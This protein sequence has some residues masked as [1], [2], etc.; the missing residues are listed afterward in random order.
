MKYLLTQ[1][2]DG[3]KHGRVV[4]DENGVFVKG[5]D[6]GFINLIDLGLESKTL[7][8]DRN[9]GAKTLQDGGLYFQWGDTKG[10]TAE[11]CGTGE[12]QKFFTWD[13]YKYVAPNEGGFFEEFL[14]YTDEDGQLTIVDTDDAAHAADSKL[15]MPTQAQMEELWSLDKKWVVASRTETT[16]PW[17]EGVEYDDIKEANIQEGEMNFD[18]SHHNFVDETSTKKFLGLNFIGKNGNKLF[19]PA[20]GFCSEGFAL[21]RG[22]E[23]NLWSSSLS[24]DDVH[25]AVGGFVA[26]NGFAY[27]DSDGRCIGRSVRGVAAAE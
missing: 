11:Q 8:A 25:R 10:Y 21:G 9:I 13:D 4:A 5:F 19:V 14:K 17:G 26:A 6:L 3:A 2:I 23:C 7:W 18:K 27:V 1:D 24:S 12:G 16:D 15:R 20:A 22:D